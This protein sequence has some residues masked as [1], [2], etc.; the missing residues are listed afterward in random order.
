M[1]MYQVADVKVMMNPDLQKWFGATSHIHQCTAVSKPLH[2]SFERDGEGRGC[3][4]TKMHGRQEQWSDPWYP[5][6]C[7]NNSLDAPETDHKL[8]LRAVKMCVKHREVM[9]RVRSYIYN[10][11]VW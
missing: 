6:K 7:K 8:S 9:S 10:D 4:R 1:V 3:M 11:F 5:L 2:F